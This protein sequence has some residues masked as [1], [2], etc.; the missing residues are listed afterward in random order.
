MALKVAPGPKLSER[1]TL[2][3]GGRARA[4]V[5]LSSPEDAHGLADELARH[6]CRP[7]IL[8]WGSNLLAVDTDL[9]IAVVS[10]EPPQS[11]APEI[12]EQ[13]A[14][15]D[16]SGAQK[17]LVRA[18]GGLMLP[19][20][21]NWAAKLGLSGIEGLAG[22][23]G[24]VGGAVAMNAGSY[25]RETA[26]LLTRVRLWDAQNGLRWIGPAQW[27]ARYRSF[28]PD[29][30][31]PPWLVVEAELA[32]TSAAP[33]AVR[34]VVDANLARKKASQPVSAATCGCVFKNPEGGSAGRMLDEAGF[35]GKSLGGM[36]FSPMHANFLVNEG[37][38]TAVAALELIAKAREAVKARFGVELELEVR[39]VR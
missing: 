25:G 29:G 6:D 27:A 37:R 36:G 9:D 26:E 5:V 10:L 20:F 15:C 8:G 13:A 23:P 35:K 38:G 4:E 7:F 1:T 3:L 30:I 24:T 32:L 21:I 18:G 39:V 28:Q 34:A 12:V 22:I 14:C 11:G 17:V 31:A 19:K 16:G 33:E 2:R